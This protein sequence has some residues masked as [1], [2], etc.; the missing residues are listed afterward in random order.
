M[1]A[2]QQTIQYLFNLQYSGIK[3]GLDNASKLLAFLGN[4]QKK[5]PAVHLAGTNGKGSTA[6]YIYTIL[7]K[8]G[9]KVGL[10]TSPH[11][12][13][14]S[15]RIR[16]NDIY[17]PWEAIVEYTQ[18]LRPKID[19]VKATF[20]EATSAIAFQYFAENQVD[21]AVIETGLGGRLDAT[22][23]VKPLVSVI[24]PISEDHQQ[25]LGD[26]ILQIAREKA[27][28]IK[29]GIPCITNNRDQGIVRVLNETCIAVKAPF[30]S[31][32]PERN[33]QI[34]KS[35]IRGNIFDF[36]LG[37]QKYSGLETG[38]AGRH[39]TD[40]AALAFVAVKN[41]KNFNIPGDKIRFGLQQARWPGRMQIIREKP[42]VILD[43]AHNPDGFRNIL[44][45]LR[46]LFP[47]K[48]I[49]SII[50]LAKDKDYKTIADILMKHID[51]IGVVSE[52]SDRGLP[53]EKLMDQFQKRSG[54]VICYKTIQD[55]Y[56]KTLEHMSKSDILIIIG[57]HY[58]AGEF[59]QKIQFS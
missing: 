14:F 17:I 16:I 35:T 5:W 6:A 22:N 21:I 56:H 8:S 25:Y 30:I 18:A 55:A 15:E 26:D 31:I 20:F 39:Q 3:L 52:F 7:K 58:L 57:S 1:E 11:L 29:P 46:Q 49:W 24:T 40:N 9:Y 41:I 45:F 44:G 33:I 47:R 34:N 51:K 27:G 50:G 2:Y 10:Y 43:V 4:P 54:D 37:E 23:L 59:L 36:A 12:I 48:K 32:N 38:M 13:D 19:R 53:A 42:L 28:I